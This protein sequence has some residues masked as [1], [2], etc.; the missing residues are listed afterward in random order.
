M[1]WMLSASSARKWVSVKRLNEDLSSKHPV[2]GEQKHGRKASPQR[3]GRNV[4]GYT[5]AQ[6]YTGNRTS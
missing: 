5:A 3:P 2:T 1:M 6:Q 4:N